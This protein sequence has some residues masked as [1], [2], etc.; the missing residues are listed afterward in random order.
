MLT[1]RV[2]EVYIWSLLG[3]SLDGLHP[4]AHNEPNP[5]L[6]SSLQDKDLVGS[7]GD[8]IGEESRKEGQLL[9]LFGR[10]TTASFELISSVILW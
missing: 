6:V 8:E 7:N 9:E 1:P 3:S 4:R 5:L 2:E 10:Q